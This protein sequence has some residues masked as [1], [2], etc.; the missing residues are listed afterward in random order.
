MIY[1]NK[2]VDTKKWVHAI[3]SFLDSN[4]VDLNK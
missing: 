4:I 2:P 1:G 3:V